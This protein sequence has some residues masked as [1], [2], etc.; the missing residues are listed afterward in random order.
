MQIRNQPPRC[1]GNIS[2]TV[3]G[4]WCICSQYIACHED[5]HRLYRNNDD[6]ISLCIC[7][8]CK[9]LNI[10]KNPTKCITTAEYCPTQLYWHITF[11]ADFNEYNIMSGRAR[12]IRQYSPGHKCYINTSRPEQN[13]RHFADD[14]LKC[15]LNLIQIL[16]NVFL[17]V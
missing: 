3:G 8:T 17:R 6:T 7:T 15:I 5:W 12:Y 10:D 14:L 1:R 13:G 4:Q 2:K 16:W 9:W 11:G